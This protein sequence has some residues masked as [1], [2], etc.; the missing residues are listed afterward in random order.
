LIVQHA[1]VITFPT[2]QFFDDYV[3]AEGDVISAVER[4]GEFNCFCAEGDVGVRGK[5]TKGC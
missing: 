2:C 5:D 4:T 1:H 3:S